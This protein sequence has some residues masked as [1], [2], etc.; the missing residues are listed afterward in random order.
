MEEIHYF[1][2][3]PQGKNRDVKKI[4]LLSFDLD[5]TLLNGQQDISTRTLQA[6][7]N[8]LQ[9]GVKVTIS[10]GRVPVMMRLYAELIDL[11][12]PIIFANGAFVQTLDKH[13]LFRKKL[14]DASINAVS[15]FC[16]ENE[17]HY[18]LLCE[19]TIYFT[20]GNP[21]A[22]YFDAYAALCRKYNFLVP[23]RKDITLNMDGYDGEEIYKLLVCSSGPDSLSRL[24]H[25]LITN[26]TFSYTLSSRGLFD[27]TAKGTDKGAGIALVADYYGI[28]LS[29]V[30]AF[31]DYENDIQ[32]FKRVGISVAMGNAIPVIQKI[33][34]YHTAGNDNDGIAHALESLEKYY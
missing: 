24:K 31:G 7:Q 28:P 13:I 12:G 5:G 32:I 17:L 16:R 15:L 29:E 27:I 23:Q 20:E 11:Q 14:T 6:V 2:K 4:S 18:G 9:K 26:N 8:A 3:N 21:R 1:R 25:M 33:A 10:S 19:N 34:D 22:K 30:C